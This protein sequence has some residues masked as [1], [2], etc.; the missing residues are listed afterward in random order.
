LILEVPK[1]L[2]KILKKWLSKHPNITTK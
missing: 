1:I 2:L